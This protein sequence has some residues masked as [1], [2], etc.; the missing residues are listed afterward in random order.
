MAHLV[1]FGNGVRRRGCGHGDRLPASPLPF[2]RG[3]QLVGAGV[4]WWLW[5]GPYSGA[6]DLNRAP[7]VIGNADPAGQNW[8]S[9]LA[10][11][12]DSPTGDKYERCRL[13]KEHDH[14]DRRDHD[15]NAA[16]G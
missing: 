13:D 6:H 16:D 10:I 11:D 9:G 14:D 2:Q 5:G 3:C 7:L 8:R 15:Y 1:A 12:H 4:P